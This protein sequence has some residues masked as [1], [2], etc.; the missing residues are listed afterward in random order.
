MQ[1]TQV[2]TNMDRSEIRSL[3]QGTFVWD[4]HTC[5]PLRLD[6]EY[7]PQLRRAR[8][9]GFDVV[10]L[11]VGFG[12]MNA[13][14]HLKQLAFFRHW[15][16]RHADEFRLVGTVEEIKA[17]KLE[18]RLGV[19]FDIEGG[20]ALDERL[21]LVELY[22]ELGVRWMLLVYNVT[23]P[24]GGGCQDPEDPGLTAF[25]RAVVREMER[26]GML[27]CCTHVGRRTAL[28]VLDMAERPVIFSH[29]NPRALVDHPRNIDDE[30]IRKCAAPGGVIGINGVGLFLGGNDI[31]AENLARHID[32]VVQTA[33]PEHVGLGLD[34]VYDMTELIEFVRQHPEQFP[35]HLGYADGVKFAPP[36]TLEPLV[37]ALFRRGYDAAHVRGILGG[38]FLRLARQVWR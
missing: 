1:A 7:L 2:Q 38:N 21:E 11:N 17:A 16:R 14:T 27:V 23:N 24:L 29:S 8:E 6:D 5:M 25:G 37:A 35:A 28:D 9:S 32:H 13:D 18:G 3:L 30:L 34:Y 19:F 15:I 4:N 33:G 36:E 12:A 31:G 22:Y 10:G 26:V 20:N